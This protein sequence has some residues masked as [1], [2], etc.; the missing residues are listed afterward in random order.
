MNK[1][2]E[3]HIWDASY[4]VSTVSKYKN[5]EQIKNYVRSQGKSY[6]ILYRGNLKTFD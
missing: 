2:R 5:D 4:F 6:T 3:G 1:L